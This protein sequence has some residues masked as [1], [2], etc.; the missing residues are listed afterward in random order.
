[1]PIK[2]LL[3]GAKGMLAQTVARCAPPE[4]Q[5]VPLDLPEFDLTDRALV[6]RTFQAEKPEVVINCAAFTQVDACEAEEVLATKVN[7]DGPGNLARAARKI[8]ATLVQISTDYVFDGLA[9]TPYSETDPTAPQS[10][11]G[12]SKLLG[13]EAIRQS[14]LEKYFIVRTSWLYGP[15]G[16][17]FVET[18][19]RLAAERDELRVVADQVGGPTFTGDLAQG[20]FNLLALKSAPQAAKA[21]YGTYHFSNA[22]QC[23][24]YDFA[25]EILTL[26]RECGLPSKAERIV[27][28]RTE[29]YPL[30]ARR[31]AYSVFDTSQYQ[32]LTGASI[33]R[34]E[35]SL[36]TYF[37]I[38]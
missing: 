24:W 7:G 1:M 6:D 15:G 9:T 28:I 21:P 3:V 20:L 23:S 31:P 16:K 22:G 11:Y 32:R 36:R 5:I 38:R 4:Y 18:I 8:D 29:D 10:A 2:V 27:A 12:R 14:G 34:W 26:A 19:L 35:V 13:E 30:P 17:N 25:N 33:P 37:D